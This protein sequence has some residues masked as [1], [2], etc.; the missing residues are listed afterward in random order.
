MDD[1]IAA[2]LQVTVP[3]TLLQFGVLFVKSVHVDDASN[4][5]AEAVRSE[6]VTVVLADKTPSFHAS[7]PIRLFEEPASYGEEINVPLAAKPTY[8]IVTSSND[9]VCE[10]FAVESVA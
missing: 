4:A 5:D 1:G 10:R 8:D 3:L 7:D 9:G 2:A 6:T